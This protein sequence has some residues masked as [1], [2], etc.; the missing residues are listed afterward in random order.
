MPLSLSGSHQYSAWYMQ[1]RRRDRKGAVVP[2]APTDPSATPSVGYIDI[3]WPAQPGVIVNLYRA[4][5]DSF[6][7]SAL[8]QSFIDSAEYR[9]ESVV[10]STSYWY[11][12][13]VSNNVG[14]S[15]ESGSAS[16][17]AI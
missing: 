14:E 5:S 17:T 16:A 10:S 11:W 7:S 12:I 3:S 13:T 6:G 8:V 4:E 15:G 2:V 1:D 9:D